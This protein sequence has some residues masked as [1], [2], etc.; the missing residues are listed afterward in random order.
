MM[1]IALLSNP[2]ICD[3]NCD[4]FKKTHYTL[5]VLLFYRLIVVAEREIVY[6]KFPIPLINRLEKH[7]VSISTM[8]LEEQV[9]LSGRLEQWLKDFC[10]VEIRINPQRYI[11]FISFSITMYNVILNCICENKF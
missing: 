4:S 7:I 8:L 11:C 3:C 1:I 10:H 9:Y 6:K 2:T 5:V